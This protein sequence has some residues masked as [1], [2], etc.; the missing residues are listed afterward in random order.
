M[1][2]KKKEDII[3]VKGEELLDVFDTFDENNNNSNQEESVM[4]NQ[5]QNN[6]NNNQKAPMSPVVKNLIGGAA[7]VAVGAA[8]CYFIINKVNDPCNSNNTNA[9]HD[10]MHI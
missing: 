3:V 7:C 9:I 4:N 1:A 5:N 2:G 8:A 10:P 6:Q